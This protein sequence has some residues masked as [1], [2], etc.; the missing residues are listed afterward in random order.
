LSNRIPGTTRYA[1]ISDRT[2]HPIMVEMPTNTPNSLPP[3]APTRWSFR[4]RCVRGLLRNVPRLWMSRSA[5]NIADALNRIGYTTRK[6]GVKLALH[7]EAFSMFRNT[8]DVDLF[9]ALHRP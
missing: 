4:C 3:V 7:P 8:R 9:Y 5:E 1:D 2:D 6:R